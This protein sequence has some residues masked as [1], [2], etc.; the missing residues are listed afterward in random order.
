MV[1]NYLLMNHLGRRLGGQHLDA[2]RDRS[3][4]VTVQSSDVYLFS[5][6]ILDYN[7]LWTGLS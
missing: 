7:R 6:S 5:T 4:S 3:D 2:V 1:V